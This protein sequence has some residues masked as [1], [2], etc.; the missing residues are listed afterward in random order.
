MT[1]SEGTRQEQ[2]MVRTMGTSALGALAFAA[3]IYVASLIAGAHP[4]DAAG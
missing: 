4:A 3:L 2:S 1:P